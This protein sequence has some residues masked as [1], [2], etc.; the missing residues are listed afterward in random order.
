MAIKVSGCIV[1]YNSYDKC[2]E[3]VRSILSNTKGVELTLYV[4]DN[5]SKEDELEKLKNE[6]PEI[7]AIQ[8]QWNGDRKSVV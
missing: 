1:N 8:S 5:A 4:V 3:T 2:R 7:V 6:F